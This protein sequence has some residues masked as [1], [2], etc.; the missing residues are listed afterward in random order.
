M[1]GLFDRQADVYARVRPTY[2]SEL[3]EKLAG[4]TPCHGLAWDVGTGSGQAAIGVSVCLSGIYVPG[5]LISIH[6]R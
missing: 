4:L 6:Y 5:I 1:A 2:P 3:Y